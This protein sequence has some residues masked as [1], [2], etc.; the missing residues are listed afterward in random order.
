[1][2]AGEAVSGHYVFVFDVANDWF[3]GAVFYLS[4]DVRGHSALLIGGKD[5]VLER[6][7]DTTNL[8]SRRAA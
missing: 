1:M 4:F 7:F 6:V 2:S 8:C 3:D 5:I